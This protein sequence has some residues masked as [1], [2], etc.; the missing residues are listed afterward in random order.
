MIIANKFTTAKYPLNRAIFYIHFLL[1]FSFIIFFVKYV[2]LFILPLILIA[3]LSIVF[4]SLTIIDYKNATKI[5][6]IKRAKQGNLYII[7]HDPTFLISNEFNGYNR[8]DILMNRD[9][10]EIK[11]MIELDSSFI[12]YLICKEIDLKDFKGK[13]HLIKKGRNKYNLYKL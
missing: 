9:S 2:K 12:K 7:S 10:E 5:E 4:I 8:K 1:L 3:S 6:L 13:L 11:K